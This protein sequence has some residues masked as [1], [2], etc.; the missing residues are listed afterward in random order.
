MA[1]LG[2]LVDQPTMAQAISSGAGLS[3][4][5]ALEEARVWLE[6]TTPPSAATPPDVNRTTVD[7]DSKTAN[8]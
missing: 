4:E 6:S 2:R 8:D 3:Y 1:S 7:S 5:A